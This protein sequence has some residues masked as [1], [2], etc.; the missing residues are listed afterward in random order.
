MEPEGTWASESKPFWYTCDDGTVVMETSRFHVDINREQPG[1]KDGSV[2]RGKLSV[3]E[4]S[5]PTFEGGGI[6]RQFMRNGKES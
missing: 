4:R 2:F 3:C 6:P 1:V 5:E